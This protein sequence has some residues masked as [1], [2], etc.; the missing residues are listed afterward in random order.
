MRGQSRQDVLNQLLAKPS[1]HVQKFRDDLL[2]LELHFLVLLER[3]FIDQNWGSF[4][5]RFLLNAK[6]L[7]L[8]VIYVFNFQLDRISEELGRNQEIVGVA[9]HAMRCILINKKLDRE[10]HELNIINF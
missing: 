5:C 3:R 10:I 8:K 4:R 7:M 9:K 2:V 6:K 1:P